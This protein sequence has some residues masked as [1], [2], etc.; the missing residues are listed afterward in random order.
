MHVPHLSADEQTGCIT[1]TKLIWTVV[2]L[3]GSEASG[4]LTNSR[5]LKCIT[6]QCLKSFGGQKRGGSSEPS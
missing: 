5:D 4:Q 6:R 1:A 2:I 3:N